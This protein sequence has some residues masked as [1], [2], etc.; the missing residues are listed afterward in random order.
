[1]GEYVKR[2]DTSKE[3]APQSSCKAGYMD[4]LAVHLGWNHV[5][6][7]DQETD[8]GIPIALSSRK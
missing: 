2:E 7:L 8:L 1:M 3:L 5:L 6:V 4:R